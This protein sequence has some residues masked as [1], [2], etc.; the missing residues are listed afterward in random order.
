MPQEHPLRR[1]KGLADAALGELS[2]VFDEM[3]SAVGQPSIPPERR[4]KASLLMGCTRCAVRGVCANNST[5]WF[6]RV[7]G[8]GGRRG[9]L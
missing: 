8:P 3:Y 6:P 7:S 9:E 2:A 4:W 5:N 1:V